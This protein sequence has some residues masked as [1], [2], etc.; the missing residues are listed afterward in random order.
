MERCIVECD[1]LIVETDE[2]LAAAK[3]PAKAGNKEN[4]P[5]APD[6]HDSGGAPANFAA[7]L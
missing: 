2:R 7:A 3:G 6:A 5:N 4:I 1:R